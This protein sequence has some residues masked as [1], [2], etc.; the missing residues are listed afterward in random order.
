MLHMVRKILEEPCM[1]EGKGSQCD[2]CSPTAWKY[3]QYFDIFYHLQLF[4]SENKM[5]IFGHDLLRDITTSLTPHFQPQR[6][7]MN[8]NLCLLQETS[9]TPWFRV[10]VSKL[11]TAVQLKSHPCPSQ[12]LRFPPCCCCS[13]HPASTQEQAVVPVNPVDFGAGCLGRCD[14]PQCLCIKTSLWQCD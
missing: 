1:A 3:D 6:P 8:G 10:A 12:R 4:L 13:L 9:L 14:C 7:T 2:D 5:L 11:E